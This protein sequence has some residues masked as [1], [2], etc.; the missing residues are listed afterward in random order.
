MKHTGV[1]FGLA[2]LLAACWLTSC[3]PTDNTL[4][5]SLVP[6]NQDITIKT[7]T[8]DLPLQPMQASGDLQSRISSG[9]DIGSIGTEF[10][11]EGLVSVTPAI[12]SIVWGKDPAVQR[13][14]LSMVLDTA[15]VMRDDQKAIP[16]NIYVHRL[17]FEL[18]STC[19]NGTAE[20]FK[21]AY[22]DAEPISTG[23]C[24]Y[25]GDDAWSIELK[26]EIGEELL[27]FPMATLDSAELFMKQFYGL[28]MRTDHP[29]DAEVSRDGEG[30][31]NLFDLSSSYLILNWN[32]TDDDGNRKTSS[33]YFSLG[34]KHA[35]NLYR[36]LRTTT[37][38][39]DQ[40][41]VQGLTGSKPIVSG[42]HLKHAVEGWAIRSGIPP[43]NLVIAK[44]IVEFPFEYTGTSSQFD[45]YALNLFPCQRLLDDDGVPYYAP[46]EEINDTA[47]EDGSINRSLLCYKSN[48]SL[49]LQDLLSMDDDE[50]DE[51]DDLWFMPTYSYYN[52]TTGVTYY[53]A[54]NFY[55]SQTILNGTGSLR[56][57]VLKL[58]Y[59]VLK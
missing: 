27:R 22:Y 6:S 25:T 41:V 18:D 42:L 43:E 56:H 48:I 8:L 28:C 32:Y 51:E 31:L 34:A 30:R 24:I 17:N 47:L 7:E 58:T 4:G 59:S 55:Y 46:I 57:P 16:Q 35:M 23:G 21:T 1:F 36:T 53:Y 52:S 5:S 15:L 19:R 38:T 11:S 44:A 29:D 37:A 50:I 45:H 13:V 10:C 12:D 2:A 20:R 54:D 33:A 49:Y 39:S 3:I 9:L 40:I 14:Y 26:K